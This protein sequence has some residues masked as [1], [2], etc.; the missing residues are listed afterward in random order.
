MF[1]DYLTTVILY[2]FIP[3]LVKFAQIVAFSDACCFC[4]LFIAFAL[5]R[6]FIFSDYIRLL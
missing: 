2:I 5:Q 6:Y 3:P 4:M 1:R